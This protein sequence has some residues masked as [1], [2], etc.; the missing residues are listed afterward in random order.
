[1]FLRVTSRP[2][3]RPHFFLFTLN[4][5]RFTHRNLEFRFIDSFFLPGKTIVIG[6]LFGR[7][8]Q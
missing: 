5:A 7:A 1:M 2:E 6:Y 4:N 8:V 3:V